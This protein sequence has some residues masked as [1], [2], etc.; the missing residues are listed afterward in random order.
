[1]TVKELI[2]KLL[3]HPTNHIVCSSTKDAVTFGVVE[4]GG[5]I[6]HYYTLEGMVDLRKN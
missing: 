6:I 1:M 5:S 3:E 2:I 4:P